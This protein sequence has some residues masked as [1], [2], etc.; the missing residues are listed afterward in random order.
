ME[1]IVDGMKLSVEEM[2][3]RAPRA[4]LEWYHGQVE[5]YVADKGMMYYPA[6]DPLPKV[7]REL[8]CEAGKVSYFEC[9]GFRMVVGFDT[10]HVQRESFDFDYFDFVRGQTKN[11]ADQISK[12]LKNGIILQTISLKV[13]ELRKILAAEENKK[14]QTFHIEGRFFD[15]GDLEWKLE[16]FNVYRENG[17][18][19]KKSEHLAVFPPSVSASI[20]RGLKFELINDEMEKVIKA[21]LSELERTKDPN[22]IYL[23]NYLNTIRDNIKEAEKTEQTQVLG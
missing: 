21:E 19:W 11:L 2:L 23:S 18:W 3:E 1:W 12:A 14:I 7:I 17:A 16:P 9:D 22:A 5:V 15:R 4:I 10:P 6:S 8:K 13:S 20:S